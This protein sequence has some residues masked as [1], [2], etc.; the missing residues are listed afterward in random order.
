MRRKG[1]HAFTLVEVMIVVAI[2]GLLAA[3]ALPSFARAR[4]SSRNA[5]YAAD[6]RTAT[7][8]F[9]EYAVINGEYPPDRTPGIIPPGMGEYLA[10]MR[11]TEVN[12]L[13]GRWDWDYLQFGTVAGVSVYGPTADDDQLIR[14]DQL[15]DNGDLG[16]GN[17]RQRS[18]GYIA[19]IE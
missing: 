5:R 7:G 10:K 3:I 4:E 6:L 8:A 18:G 16:T 12:T 17:F 19:V 14:L 13:G 2:I 15:I 9:Q 11:W 1:G